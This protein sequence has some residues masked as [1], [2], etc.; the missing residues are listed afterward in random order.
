TVEGIEGTAPRITLFAH[1]GFGRL[2]RRLDAMGNEWSWHYDAC[3]NTIER[4]VDGELNDQPGGA[5]NVRLAQTL[6]SYDE[7]NHLIRRSESFFDPQ[8]QTPFENGEVVT[9]FDHTDSGLL[10]REI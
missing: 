1:D 4:R 9:R 2:R 7:M 6:S 8:T 10:R 3:G 5:S